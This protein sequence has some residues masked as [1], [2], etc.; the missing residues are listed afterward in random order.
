M[1]FKNKDSNQKLIEKLKLLLELNIVPEKNYFISQDL[2]SLKFG[3]KGEKD[4]AYFINFFYEHSTKWAVIHDLRIEHKGKVAQIDHILINRLF[5]FY[6]LESKSYSQ[7]LEINYKGEFLA[8]YNNKRIGIESP[9]EQNERHIHLFSSFLKYNSILPKRLGVEIKPKFFN[10][11]LISPKT[12]IKRPLNSKLNTENVIKADTLRS[13]IKN[14]ADKVP[15]SEIGRIVTLSSFD[16]IANMARTI[17]SYHKTFSIDLKKKYGV[18]KKRITEA[19]KKNTSNNYHP[20]S[21]RNI[22]SPP[23]PFCNSEMVIRKS[24]AGDEFWGCPKFPKCRGTRNIVED[25][26]EDGDDHLGTR[27]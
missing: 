23:C 19:V 26:R 5:D 27:A 4:A 1:I 20:I 7:K 25:G 9:I 14:N 24:K 11:I 17:V 6:I 15:I 8:V 16:T 3:D 18:T 10:Y 12:T 13:V 21:N 2:K 22:Y